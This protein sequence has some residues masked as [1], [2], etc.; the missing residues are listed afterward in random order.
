VILTGVRRIEILARVFRGLAFPA[1]FRSYRRGPK[2]YPRTPKRRANMRA[3]IESM[4]SEI[5]QSIE[6]LRRHL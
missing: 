6:L 5:K 4:T 3:E 2:G 1:R